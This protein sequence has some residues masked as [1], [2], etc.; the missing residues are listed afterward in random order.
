[1]GVSTDMSSVRGVLLDRIEVSTV[2]HI[3]VSKAGDAAGGRLED[4]PYVQR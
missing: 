4:R 3:L 1:M 2:N